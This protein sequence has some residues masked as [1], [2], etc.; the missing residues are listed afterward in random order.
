M[1]K[2]L[3]LFFSGILISILCY[4]GTIS[5]C[6]IEIDGSG[7]SI[8]PYIIKNEQQ[9]LAISKDLPLSA[10]YK[11][12]NDIRL[13]TKSWTP[14]GANSSG[15]FTGVF[16]G[17]GHTI[18]NL[19]IGEITNRYDNLGLFAVNNGTISNL[20]IDA[21]IIG[22]SENIGIIAGSGT[23]TISNCITSGNITGSFSSC[24][25]GIV[26]K[27]ATISNCVSNCDINVTYKDASIP[28]SPSVFIG[29]I[30]GHSTGNIS[31]CNFKG[32]IKVPEVTCCGGIVGYIING[33]ITNCENSSSINV[34]AYYLGG[35]VGYNIYSNI[36]GCG[37]KSDISFTYPFSLSFD[38]PVEARIGGLIG[39]NYGGTTTKYSV[40]DCYNEGVISLSATNT[41][42]GGLIGE[43]YVQNVKNC[44]NTG[45]I[46]NVSKTG[47]CTGGLI[48]I[49]SKSNIESCYSE[50][51]IT[52]T[53][54]PLR[55]WTTASNYRY[56]NISGGLIGKNE[57]N[58][59]IKNC[60]S[61]GNISTTTKKYP[62][63]NTYYSY[64]GGLIG[65]NYSS[66]EN[67]LAIVNSFAIVNIRSE[68][69]TSNDALGDEYLGG[70]I[71]QN[72]S[73]DYIKNCYCI[74][75]I[76]PLN[77]NTK[78]YTDA[79]SV[80]DSLN[81]ENCFYNNSIDIYTSTVAYGLTDNEMKNTEN[82]TFWDFD[83]TWKIDPEINNGYPNLTSTSQTITGI[84]ISDTSAML[85]VGET[86]KLTI[87]VLPETVI[88]KNV[89][90]TSS[91]ENIASVDSNGNIT[92]NSIG[93]AVITASTHN[94]IHSAQCY[95]TVVADESDV[96]E[97]VIFK[98]DSIPAQAGEKILVPV[99]I[100]KNVTGISSMNMDIKYD[101]TVLTPVAVSTENC[102]FINLESDINYSSDTIR[103]SSSNM[104]N[105]TDV[106]VICYIEF[107][108]S[109]NA[110]SD[111]Y[112]LGIKTNEFK[113]F[114]G[115]TTKDSIPTI[116]SGN[117]IIGDGSINPPANYE[118]GDVDGDTYITAMDASLVLE[119]AL[120]NS[121]KFPIEK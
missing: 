57:N 83:T 59:I 109:K 65:Y 43:N 89:I 67:S 44:Y 117:I 101:N 22:N 118:Y 25:G 32:S 52:Q 88:N 26:G 45:N 66:T 115:N 56:A 36:K 98:I 53:A 99:R 77:T 2:I 15:A 107:E 13:I 58:N 41:T 16:D 4:I 114:V 47:A 94:G 110:L 35:I 9:L 5:V 95:I 30:V 8:S 19:N 90:W 51:D 54:A 34:K 106:G 116:Y 74:A 72:Y 33:S 78:Q 70:F 46:T 50:G 11:L 84:E 24:V 104:S 120:N 31:N 108:I 91:N 17:N 87:S 63:Q 112:S 55:Y 23:G 79:F 81:Y 3:K 82:Y 80:S 62:G 64:S 38:A 96:N 12:D 113:T 105:K 7:T 102:I 48:G 97:T 18:T 20:T 6:A 69:A 14:I 49:N 40:T 61:N 100:T 121:F 111:F 92:A 103:L 29:G 71:G 119:K 93:M 76:S 86:K 39:Y 68:V 42:V 37:N 1:K 73:T 60:Y 75:K 10:N 28:T 21:N 85:I 27:G